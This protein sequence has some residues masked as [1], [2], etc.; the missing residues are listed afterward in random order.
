MDELKKS[1]PAQ[2]FFGIIPVV[3]DYFLCDAKD[4]RAMGYTGRIVSLLVV[5]VSLLLWEIRNCL[6]YGTSVADG[7]G[8]CSFVG[9]A[10][11]CALLGWRIGKKYDEAI[12]YATK[13][14][15][16]H[17][18]NR[19]YVYTAFPKLQAEARRQR[20]PLCVLMIDAN[21]FKTVNDTHGHEFGDRVL[22]SI[23]NVLKNKTRKRDVVARWGGDEFLVLLPCTGRKT[24][25][26]VVGQIEE[27][28]HTLSGRMGVNVSTSIG[29]AVYPTDAKQ[30][31]DLVRV[32]D[33]DMYRQ[34]AHRDNPIRDGHDTAQKCIG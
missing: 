20:K 21:H 31:N 23:A 4:G 8:V 33:D 32:A 29:M 14:A 13:D 16:T 11:C 15:L 30:L 12:F 1:Y 10:G 19:R 24:A 5:S 25:G 28:L 34:K 17:T 26:K 18:Y 7:P 3:R 6:L 2:T 9:L 22:E 27:E